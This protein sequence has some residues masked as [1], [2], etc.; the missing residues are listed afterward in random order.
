MVGAVRFELTTSCTRNKRASQATLR[1]DKTRGEKMP[2]WRAECN[3]EVD[4]GGV[5]ARIQALGPSEVAAVD[6]P[7]QS[8]LL[9]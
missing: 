7:P 5:L 4:V 9:L 3:E 6:R 8:S 2:I 1:P